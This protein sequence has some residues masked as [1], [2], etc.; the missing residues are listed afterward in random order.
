MVMKKDMQPDSV[1]VLQNLLNQTSVTRPALSPT[2][3]LEI[4]I[5]CQKPVLL[6]QEDF[7]QNVS[8]EHP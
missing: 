2:S 4:T 1:R 8:D 5:R 3:F 6:S 7:I